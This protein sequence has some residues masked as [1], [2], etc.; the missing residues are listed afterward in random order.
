MVLELQVV[1]KAHV[2]VSMKND[3][4]VFRSDRPSEYPYFLIFL[5]TYQDGIVIW[6]NIWE[7]K[8]I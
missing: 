6:V 5:I 4:F 8:F 3:F 1:S 2:E 7:T